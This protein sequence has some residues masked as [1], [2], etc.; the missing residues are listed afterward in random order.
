MKKLIILGS[1]VAVLVAGTIAFNAIPALGQ[2]GPFSMPFSRNADFDQDNCPM[3]SGDTSG[4]YVTCINSG[5]EGIADFLG[6]TA[7]ELT[8]EL[9]QGKT[10]AQIAEARNIT[11]DALIEAVIASHNEHLQTL[12]ANDNIT[13]E[14]AEQML[15]FM[16]EK[17][18]WMIDRVHDSSGFGGPGWG[19]M[20]GQGMMGSSMMGNGMMGNGYA[21]GAGY[22]GMMGGSY[23][24][25]TGYGGMMG[26]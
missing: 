20:H 14:Q 24:N 17:A 21:N 6:L 18:N 5:M 9:Q 23:A 19:G 26:R 1:L 2:R 22:G 7:D 3:Q 8:L 10:L 13:A 25:G 12:V 16:T 15:A 4:E 11:R